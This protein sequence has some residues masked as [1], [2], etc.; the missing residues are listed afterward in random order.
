MWFPIPNRFLFVYTLQ[1]ICPSDSLLHIDT[2]WRIQNENIA[3]KILVNDLH[4]GVEGTVFRNFP[5]TIF[6][7]VYETL[8]ILAGRLCPTNMHIIMRLFVRIDCI[9]V[10]GWYSDFSI[11]PNP[12]ALKTYR[13]AR[14]Q[15]HIQRTFIITRKQTHPSPCCP[16]PCSG[17]YCYRSG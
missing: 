15:H 5:V 7:F 14:V 10:Y 8:K 12:I 3:A 6:R 9:Y 11:H 2:G 16:L 17:C 1:Y 4:Y 13:Q